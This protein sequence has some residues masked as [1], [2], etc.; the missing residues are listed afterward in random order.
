MGGESKN[1]S[2]QPVKNPTNPYANM[3]QNLFFYISANESYPILL[4]PVLQLHNQPSHV[5]TL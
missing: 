2:T 4:C 1:F 3:N 5:Y